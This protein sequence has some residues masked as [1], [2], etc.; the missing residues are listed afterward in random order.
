MQSAAGLRAYELGWPVWLAQSAGH[1]MA[2]CRS[3]DKESLRVAVQ[4]A[5]GPAISYF[6]CEAA[7][8][9]LEAPGIGPER[10]AAVA[11][12]SCIMSAHHACP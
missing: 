3:F 1:G 12:G 2:A 5:C 11:L 4:H 7:S 9:L 10:A 8:V 6:R